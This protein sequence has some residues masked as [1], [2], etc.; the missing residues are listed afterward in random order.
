MAQNLLSIDI[1]EDFVCGLML[2]VTGMSATVVS[3]DI[4]VRSEEN[5]LA[6]SV[7]EVLN[8]LGYTNQPCRVS[9]AAEN[10]FYRNLSFPFHDKRKI[11]KILSIELEDTTIVDM[12][13]VLVDSLVT[14]KK[15]S[16]SAVVAA[17]IDKDLLRQKLAEL[18]ELKLDPEIVAISNVQTAL[19]LSRIQGRERFVLLDA[20]CRR[21]TMYIMV[22]GRMRLIRTTVFEAGSGANF[23]MDKNTGQVF[24]KRPEKIEETFEVLCRGIRHTLYALEDIE[25]DVPIFLTGPLADVRDSREHIGANLGCEVL[26]CDLVI[27]PV[28]VGGECGPWRGE[29]MTS[30]LAL[31][32][33]SGRRR[34]GF[35]FRKDE[36]VR[37]ASLAKYRRLIP[38][39]GIPLLLCLVAAVIYLWNDYYVK[40]KRLQSLKKQGEQIFTATLPEVT[41]I[42][43][44]VQQLK[45]EIREM[46][47]GMLG[48]A[49]LASDLKLLDLMAEISVRIPES[50]NVHVI[51]MVADGNSILLRGLTDNFNSVDSLKKVLEESNY[52]NIVTINSANV[53]SQSTDIRF[54]L[55]LELNRG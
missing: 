36:F 23:T 8:H 50:I 1:G 49:K 42:I 12:E 32:L 43:D 9:L 15:G 53:A 55:R 45:V 19:Q 16:K 38:R 5:T 48:D 47:K 54:E 6:E 14:G 51:R 35:N 3:C 22:D 37:K 25:A 30:A 34:A 29:L 41:R 2:S 18:A 33:R 11:D 17:M 13:D 28:K 10:F 39:L 24:A 27:P 26:S 40:E 46:K 52:F 20:G 31:G 7:T 4:S 44:P 21:A